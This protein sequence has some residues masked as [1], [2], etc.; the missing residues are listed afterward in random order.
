MVEKLK[1]ARMIRERCQLTTT[2]ARRELPVVRSAGS[3]LEPCRGG[4]A[5]DES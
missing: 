2:R 1:R 3:P 4:G 5:G